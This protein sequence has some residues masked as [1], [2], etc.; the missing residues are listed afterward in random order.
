MR[1]RRSLWSV[2]RRGP[3]GVGGAPPRGGAAGIDVTP[4]GVRVALLSRRRGVAGRAR[5][6]ALAAEPLPAGAYTGAADGDWAAV[7]RALAAALERA[8]AAGRCRVSR[9]VMALPEAALTVAAVDLGAAGAHDGARAEP[10]VLA[11]AEQ[12]T[13]LARDTLACD[14]RPG[15]AGATV[16][17]AAERAHVDARLEAAA[18]AGV[19]LTAIDGEPFAA[20]RALRF[21]AAR[22]TP[23]GAPCLAIWIGEAGVHG[24]LVDGGRVAQ[25]IGYP[26]PEHADLADALRELA[27][28]G[29]PAYALIAGEIGGPDGARLALADLADLLGCAAR[30]FG[31]V[32]LCEPGQPVDETL[33]RAPAFAVAVGLALRGVDE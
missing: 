4:R 14:W 31:C 19:A 30:P 24:W 7:G 33:V 6:D 5:V 27:R 21:V 23:G 15:A 8:R 25:A 2:G 10:A 32:S 1:E 18:T 16:F 9:A 17:A 28:A 22:E 13:G 20:L 29:A 12:A 3:A 11:A 26:T